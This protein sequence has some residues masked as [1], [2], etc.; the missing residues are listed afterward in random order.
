MVPCCTLW[1]NESLVGDVLNGHGGPDVLNQPDGGWVHG[2]MT[3][4]IMALLY[5]LDCSAL[6]Y[7]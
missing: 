6:G 2:V 7:A 3:G 4:R 1:L 5:S